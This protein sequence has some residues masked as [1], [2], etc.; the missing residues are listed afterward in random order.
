MTS[1]YM[2][3]TPDGRFYQNTEG[4]CTKSRPILD[5]GAHVALGFGYEKF[6][7]RGGAHEL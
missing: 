4:R 5:V 7:R 6:E 1:S 2:M 3:M